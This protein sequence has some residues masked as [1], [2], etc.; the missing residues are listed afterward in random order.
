MIFIYFY[1]DTVRFEMW[2][3]VSG[4]NGT[5]LPTVA[6]CKCYPLDQWMGFL[7]GE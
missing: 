6:R 2:A 4:Q 7:L 5:C 3:Q 1:F